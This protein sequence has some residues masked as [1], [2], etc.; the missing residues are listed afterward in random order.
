MAA[1]Y[2]EVERAVGAVAGVAS[3][4]VAVAGDTGRGRLRIRLE[5]DQDAAAVSRAVSVVLRDQFDIDIDPAD[6]RPRPAGQPD[7]SVASPSPGAVSPNGSGGGDAA[8][9]PP[10]P[11]DRADASPLAVAVGPPAEPAATAQPAAPVARPPD[12]EPVATVVDT[13]PDDGVTVTR[14]HTLLDPAATAPGVRLR[15]ALTD[16]T[17]TSR[18]LEVTVEVVLE[19]D[20]RSAR[21]T[22][23]TAAIPSAR[24]RAIAE[25]T[26]TALEELCGERLRTNVERIEQV[27]DG[28]DEHVTVVVSMVTHDHQDQLVGASLVRGD[29]EQ[30]VARAALDAVNRRTGPLL[31]TA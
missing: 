22:V 5:P 19:L 15:V 25:A 29:I 16:L 11:A 4:V 14:R 24:L 6:I 23:R 1:T 2:H 7:L 12:L 10:E 31:A 20:G 27:P 13:P 3:A 9:E 28:D 18:S 21:G 17:M 26:L 8:L 30:A